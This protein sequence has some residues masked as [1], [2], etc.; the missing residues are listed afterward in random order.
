[1]PTMNTG[2]SEMLPWV[3]SSEKSCG[4]FPAISVSTVRVKAE[5]S[6]RG[7]W[8]RSRARSPLPSPAL[9]VACCWSSATTG[10]G[11]AKKSDPG[12]GGLRHHSESNCCWWPGWAG[13]RR[14]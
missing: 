14:R 11:K 9:V 8:S 10:H 13:R 6:K 5:E 7:R 3:P 4:V 2:I 1:M 12:L